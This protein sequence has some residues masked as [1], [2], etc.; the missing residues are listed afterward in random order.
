MAEWVQVDQTWTATF[1]TEAEGGPQLQ[2]RRYS[3]GRYTLSV[4][5]DNGRTV[6]RAAAYPDEG[7]ARRAAVE[8]AFSVLGEAHRARIATLAR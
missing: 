8:F 5:F 7:T 4:R 6:M 3:E 2:V 1:G